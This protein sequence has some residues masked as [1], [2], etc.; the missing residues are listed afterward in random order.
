MFEPFSWM[1][2]EVLE[3]LHYRENLSCKNNY[4]RWQGTVVNYT[5]KAKYCTLVVFKL[6][7]LSPVHKIYNGL[8]LVANVRLPDASLD[9]W[10]DCCY[11]LMWAFISFFFTGSCFVMRWVCWT[12]LGNCVSI[13]HLIFYCC[14]L[15]WFNMCII[16]NKYLAIL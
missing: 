10:T 1:T 2:R 4:A 8:L 15:R 9:V 13:Y 14:Y 6:S 12:L 5:D 16:C 7:V 11:Q 3:S